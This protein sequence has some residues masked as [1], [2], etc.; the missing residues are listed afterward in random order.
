M[1][2][3]NLILAV[4]VLL[5][6]LVWAGKAHEH[7]AAKL[8]I[9]TEGKQLTI[10]LEAPLDSLLGFERAPR[11]ATEKTKVDAAVAH[12]QAADKLFK[13]ETAAG[14]R[15]AT[16]NLMAPVIGVGV[17]APVA[18]KTGHG[19]LDG[20]FV[21]ECQDTSKATQIEVLLFN[22]FPHMKR[23]DVQA[24]TSA[25]QIKRTLRRGATSASSLLL[26]TRSK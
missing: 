9:T 11:N 10:A 1:N 12:L 22:A 7:G 6:A 21:F 17:A 20:E 8:N 2:K 3:R 14:C 15:L 24:A 4:S 25:G 23:V 16:T 13:I 26:L 18:D 5:P 19:D